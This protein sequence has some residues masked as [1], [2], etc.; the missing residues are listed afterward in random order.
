MSNKAVE[1]DQLVLHPLA[2]LIIV[3]PFLASKTY[4]ICSALLKRIILCLFGLH[5][6]YFKSVCW[7]VTGLHTRQAAHLEAFIGF[8]FSHLNKP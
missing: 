5:S 4:Y 7:C 1:A 3:P 2:L 8:F 6:G